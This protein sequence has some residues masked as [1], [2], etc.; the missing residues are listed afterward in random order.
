MNMENLRASVY[1]FETNLYLCEYDLIDEPPS[2]TSHSG[3]PYQDPAGPLQLS[4]DYDIEQRPQQTIEG[5][6]GECYALIP[7][8]VVS[9]SEGVWAEVCL[10][11]EGILLYQL[12]KVESRGYEHLR[13]ATNVQMG[14]ISDSEFELPEDAVI[15]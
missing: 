10:S 14:S 1:V 15:E 9:E 2:C 6:T 8:D 12:V 7:T 5:I 4:G 3:L 13:I 11:P